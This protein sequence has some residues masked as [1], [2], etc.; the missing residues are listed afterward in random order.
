[1][2]VDLQRI[3]PLRERSGSATFL[4]NHRWDPDKDPAAA[5][6]AFAVLAERGDDFRVVLAGEPFVDQHDEHRPA[7]EALG[8]RV[9]ALG[10][11]D[12]DGYVEALHIADVVVSTALQEF[13]GISVVEAMYAGATPILPDRLVYP[14]RVPAGMRPACLYRTPAQLVD[15]LAA[16]AADPAARRADAAAL[17]ASIEQFDWS[18]IAPVTDAWLESVSEGGR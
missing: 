4:W 7:I 8:D 2:G 18:A 5:L 13:F 3:G 14:E 17:R 1:V 12:D 11:L 16:V 15:R 6:A 10:Y 9:V